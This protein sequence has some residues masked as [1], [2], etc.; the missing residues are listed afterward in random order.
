M[1]FLDI[2]KSSLA[3]TPR[4]RLKHML[5]PHEPT[6][7]ELV[8]QD[9]EHA[10]REIVNYRRFP[11]RFRIAFELYI[12]KSQQLTEAMRSEFKNRTGQQ[13]SANTFS[14][15]NS[16]S[17]IIKKIRNAALHGNPIELEQVVL[18]VYP[19]NPEVEHHRGQS[20]AALRRGWFLSVGRDLVRRPFAESFV[21]PR[22][23]L[24]LVEKKSNDPRAIENFLF[25]T[26]EYVSYVINW[27]LLE[28]INNPNSEPTEPD[29]VRLT[30][31]SF[32]IFA[33]YMHFYQQELASKQYES[34]KP[35]HMTNE[36]YKAR[37]KGLEFSNEN[38]LY[39]EGRFIPRL[40]IKL[41]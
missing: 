35:N 17:T 23:G 3:D 40:I 28:S 41:K 29:A 11:R 38:G 22:H 5:S 25:P 18:S 1:K 27:K 34:L 6:K 16:H 13:W 21:S 4:S 12:Y 31:K 10:Y 9:L 37:L 39:S 20:E 32:P 7:T 2:L 24:P 8:F 30:L 36:E 26:R 14:S 19:A 33:K 15:W